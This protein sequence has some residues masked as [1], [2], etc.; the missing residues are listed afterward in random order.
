MCA[1]LGGVDCGGSPAFLGHSCVT[2]VTDMYLCL[3]LRTLSPLLV[4]SSAD[5]RHVSETLV[6][7]H[8]SE[9]LVSPSLSLL[10]QTS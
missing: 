9:G 8:R 1:Q 6:A 4:V 3:C 5:P 2:L 10:F 7:S